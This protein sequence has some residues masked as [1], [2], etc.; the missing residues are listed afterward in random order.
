MQ[1][2]GAATI[3]TAIIIPILALGYKTMNK[4]DVLEERVRVIRDMKED[5]REIKSDIKTLL[6]ER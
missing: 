5:L 6:R 3:L 2:L 1:K 4:V